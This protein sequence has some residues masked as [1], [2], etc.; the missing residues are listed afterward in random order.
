[1]G[2]V[3][4]GGGELA[5]PPRRC[6]LPGGAAQRV[7]GAAGEILLDALVVAHLGGHGDG[8]G[9][10]PGRH[11]GGL[12]RRGLRRPTGQEGGEEHRG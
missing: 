6:L 7:G 1:M 2:V 9:L 10:G 11:H 8:G 5:P 12:P 3:H 4:Q